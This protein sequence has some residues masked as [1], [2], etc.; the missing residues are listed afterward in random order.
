MRHP[1]DRLV[2]HYIHEWS[3]GNIN[4]NIN[5]AIKLYPELISYSCYSKQ[6]EPYIKTFGNQSILPVF[7]DRILNEE[8]TELERICKFIGYEGHPEW[9]YELGAKN[10]SKE[11]IRRFPF[12]NI[13]VESKFFTI[14]RRALIP[15]SL[16]N[17]GCL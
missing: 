3:M 13:I 8:Q 10:I 14:L 5:E 1:I 17:I 2:S 16:R 15:K 7:F 12:Y 6:L 9:N 11:R 4:C